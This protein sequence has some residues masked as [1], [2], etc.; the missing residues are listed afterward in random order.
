[1]DSINFNLAEYILKE[2]EH[3]RKIYDA[4]VVQTRILER[5]ALIATGGIWSWCATHV[6]SPEVRLLKWMPAIITFLF[7][8]RAWG[9]SKA[10]QAARDYLENIE[11][12]ISLPENLGWGKYIKN[13]QE[14]RLALTAYLF[15]AILQILTVLIPI[16]YG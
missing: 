10:I 12:Y 5:Y 13:N 16:F 8:I 4:R 6:D 2:S 1:M 14:P 15:W 9:N 11:N 3:V 7:G